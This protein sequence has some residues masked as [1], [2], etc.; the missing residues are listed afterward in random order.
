MKSLMIGAA[1]LF[2]SM[3]TTHACEDMKTTEAIVKYVCDYSLVS[4]TQ[5]NMWKEDMRQMNYNNEVIINSFISWDKEL[6]DSANL[7]AEH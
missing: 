1:L 5:C 7:V 3:N 2:I 6:D 4:N